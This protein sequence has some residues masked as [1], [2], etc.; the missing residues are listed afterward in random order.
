LNN[1]LLSCVHLKC[2][3]LICQYLNGHLLDKDVL[4]IN[5]HKRM[6]FVDEVSSVHSE[7]SG[8][9]FQRDP[10]Q[11][12]NCH[13][14]RKQMNRKVMSGRGACH[15]TPTPNSLLGPDKCVIAM[16]VEED[17]PEEN[18]AENTTCLTGNTSERS[19]SYDDLRRFKHEPL[20]RSTGASMGG[21][22]SAYWSARCSRLVSN[23]CSTAVA[24]LSAIS[25]IAMVSIPKAQLLFAWSNNDSSKANDVFGGWQT[26]ECGADCQGL[27][28]GFVVKMSLLLLGVWAL[29]WRR[30]DASLPRLFVGRACLLAFVFLF[31][32][33][34]WLFY[35]VRIV[36]K[37]EPSYTVIVSYALSL[38]DALLFVH[39]SALVA[40]ELLPR[41][42]PVCRV[43]VL[44]SPD[45]FSR[46]YLLG[47][48]SVQRAAV[49]LL[50]WYYRDFPPYNPLLDRPLL[51]NTKAKKSTGSQVGTNAAPP[52]VG[53][54][55]IYD[56][57]GRSDAV[58]LSDVNAKAIMAAAARKRDS[59]HNERFYE[60]L[61]WERRVRKRKARL[62]TAVE[63]AFAHVQRFHDEKGPCSL[64]DSCEAAQAIFPALARALQ[65]YIRVTR[66]QHRF[67][68]ESIV[69]HLSNCLTYDMSAKAFLERYFNN[70]DDFYQGIQT[71]AK[72]SIVCKQLVSMNISDG[73]IFQL[74]CHSPGFDTGVSLLCRVS[75]LPFLDLTEHSIN[76]KND[77]FVL[78]FNSETSLSLSNYLL[79]NCSHMLPSPLLL[80]KI[81]ISVTNC[82]SSCQLNVTK[83]MEE[84]VSEEEIVEIQS[85]WPWTVQC[86]PNLKFHAAGSSFCWW[87]Q[88]EGRWFQ[89][90]TDARQS[91]VIAIGD[92]LKI[93]TAAPEMNGHRLLCTSAD[94]QEYLRKLKISVLLC[95]GT[96]DPC[97]GRGR[98]VWSQM[99]PQTVPIVSCVCEQG[100]YGT[101]CTEYINSA[102]FHGWATV[103]AAFLLLL[104]STILYSLKRSKIDKLLHQQ[105]QKQKRL[106]T[107]CSRVEMKPKYPIK[108]KPISQPRPATPR[109]RSKTKP[110]NLHRRRK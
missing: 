30:A 107:K 78:K 87:L 61:E 34:Y 83:L 71:P 2:R 99:A 100:Y 94:G 42:R 63:E 31:L 98:C 14:R 85:G 105:W 22:R 46:S 49:Q 73:M 51:S 74:R 7:R 102:A 11:S 40:V 54:F 101:F 20:G 97:H 70:N 77:A 106:S 44:R 108:K 89:V 92:R 58:S 80:L 93:L 57:D 41:L 55:K 43:H 28:I 48:L 76:P 62:L 25:P 9:S 6:S 18:W 35:V 104:L 29:F 1:S 75:R 79:Y 109:P 91:L 86:K 88:V 38:V 68:A 84:D 72:W 52:S 17:G 90:D 95:N 82:T 110:K 5:L 13:Q 37:A 39:Y 32:F 50:H 67:S 26:S 23:I 21:G 59:A 36:Q 56:V 96:A 65:K 47:Q 60:E 33:A 19:F 4:F 24:L 103:V 64:M 66:Q 8:Q 81:F 10:Y 12:R 16:D 15:G 53:A 69:E 27:L 3:R 45:G